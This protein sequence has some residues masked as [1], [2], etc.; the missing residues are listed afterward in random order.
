MGVYLHLQKGSVGVK[1]GVEG[2]Y[3]NRWSVWGNVAT[4]MGKDNYR[5]YRGTLGAKYDF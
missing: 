2:R 3:N 4:Q 5:N 1:V